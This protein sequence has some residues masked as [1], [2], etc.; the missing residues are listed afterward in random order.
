MLINCHRQQNIS[1]GNEEL[2]SI[3][4]RLKEMEERL[5]GNSKPR[6]EL[7]QLNLPVRDKQAPE[8]PAKDDKAR[9]RPGTARAAQPA[10]SSG[11][12]PPTPGASEGEYYIIT[13]VDL[14]DTPRWPGLLLNKMVTANNFFFGFKSTLMLNSNHLSLNPGAMIPT[15]A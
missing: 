10:P 11:N 5:R 6:P 7:T 13:H 15:T 1:K 12:M 3:E 14:D 2:A 8:V 4:A 9:S